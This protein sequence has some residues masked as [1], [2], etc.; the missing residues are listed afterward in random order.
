MTPNEQQEVLLEVPIEQIVVNPDQPRR[1]FDLSDLEE[2]AQ[3]IRQIGLIQPPVVRA[4]DHGYEL[5]AGER[6][7]RACKMAGLERI[8]VLVRPVAQQWSAEAALVENLQRVDLNPIEV[9]MA[10]RTLMDR[11]RLNQESL[12][13]RVGKKRST[14]ANY[15]RLLTL[16][17]VI[18]DS[19]SAGR[20]TMGHAKVVLSLDQLELQLLLHNRVIA[21]QLTVRDTE[22][23]A[24]QL[25]QKE[26]PVERPIVKRHSDVHLEHLE[27]ELERA[28]GTKVTIKHSGV[29]GS[30]E[31]NY[32]S[33]DD[34]DRVLDCLGVSL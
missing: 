21:D 24:E 28:L 12:A 23:L 26:K 13:L 15:L 27:R 18:R 3:S 16:P 34:L 1:E 32:Y 19:V 25:S 2:L 6:R 17:S 5:I 29:S 11:F 8:P 10:M 7:M 9:A 31:I 22:K 14:V 20:L 30:V 4:L 33:L